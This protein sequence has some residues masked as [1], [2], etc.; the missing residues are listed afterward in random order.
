MTIVKKKKTVSPRP[1][2]DSNAHLSTVTVQTKHINSDKSYAFSQS[3]GRS[4]CITRHLVYVNKRDREMSRILMKKI[5][6]F[7]EQK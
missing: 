3:S 1:L 6:S 5:S 4:Q 7:Y 2:A